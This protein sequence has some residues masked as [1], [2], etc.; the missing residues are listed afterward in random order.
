MFGQVMKILTQLI[1]LPL[2]ERGVKY[3]AHKIK[4]YDEKQKLK[5][6]NAQ[7]KAEFENAE[8]IEEVK[9]TFEKLP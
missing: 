5:K 2:V 4:E 8:T 6:E 9:S 3:F 7:K 1:L